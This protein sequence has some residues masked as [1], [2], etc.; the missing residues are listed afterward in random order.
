MQVKKVVL[1]LEYMSDP[2]NPKFPI[3]AVVEGTESP[4][5]MLARVFTGGWF[6]WESRPPEWDGLAAE[7]IE[8]PN[9]ERKEKG[10]L[11][12]ERRAP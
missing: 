4:T 1:V 2:V 10:L 3:A 5:Y 9:A 6:E 12:L 11:V 7:R 8:F